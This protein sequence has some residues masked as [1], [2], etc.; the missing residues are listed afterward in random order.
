MH[1]VPAAILVGITTDVIFYGV[2]SY[3]VMKQNGGVVKLNR[4]FRGVLPVA[5][6]GSGPTFGVFFAVYNPLKIYFTNIFNGFDESFGVLMASC[7]A[8]SASSIVGVPSDV[9]KKRLVLSSG[10]EVSFGAV[11][12]DILRKEGFKGFFVGWKANFVKDVPFAGLKLSFYEAISRLLYDKKTLDSLESGIVGFAS[13][14][15]TAV[16]TCPLDVVNTRIKSGELQGY[17]VFAA[18]QQ[19]VVRSGFLSLYMGLL[20]RRFILGFGSTIFWSLLTKVKNL[21]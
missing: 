17:G 19:V 11:G 7:V 18:H 13:G 21:S 3:K 12:R 4:A 9:I 10:R 20:P 14:V 16:V 8:G 2:D 15:M 5:T 1:E 6:T